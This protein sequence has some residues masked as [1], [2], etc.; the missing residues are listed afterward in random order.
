MV[1]N[2]LP[3]TNHMVSNQLW[4]PTCTMVSNQLQEP[5]TMVTKQLQEPPTMVS[6]QLQ[7]PTTLELHYKANRKL[8]L[9]KTGFLPV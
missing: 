8:Y 6:N 3:G 4:E 9:K 7:E 5:P 2:R 1:F